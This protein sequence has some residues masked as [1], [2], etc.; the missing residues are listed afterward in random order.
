MN[1]CATNIFKA[2]NRWPWC[3]YKLHPL[4]LPH[5]VSGKVGC[6]RARKAEAFQFALV[7]THCLCMVSP[8][9]WQARH[10]GLSVARGREAW[11][12][13][14]QQ[15]CVCRFC[16]RF[17]G[18][19]LSALQR[20]NVCAVKIDAGAALFSLPHRPT[21]WSVVAA[22]A[23]SFPEE[24]Q[25]KPRKYCPHHSPDSTTRSIKFNENRRGR[26]QCVRTMLPGQ[27]LL[28][29]SSVLP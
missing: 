22:A 25:R 1:I 8:P 5:P 13:V 20:P 14:C 21:A 19:L 23:N 16:S 2:Q 29:E 12:R 26:Q 6:Q 17:P 27:R 9:V 18:S 24:A 10:P 3:C 28:E 7:D 15:M 11:V 4:F